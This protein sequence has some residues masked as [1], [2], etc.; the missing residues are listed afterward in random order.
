MTKERLIASIVRLLKGLDDTKLKAV[1][2]FVLRL[3]K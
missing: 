1:Y 2:Q 3:T